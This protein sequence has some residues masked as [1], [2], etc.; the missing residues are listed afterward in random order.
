MVYL[1]DD[2]LSIY[3][4][5]NICAAT[6]FGFFNLNHLYMRIHTVYSIYIYIFEHLEVFTIYCKYLSFVLFLAEKGL[7]ENTGD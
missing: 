4:N 1:I 6:V 7:D 3:K 5:N 2:K